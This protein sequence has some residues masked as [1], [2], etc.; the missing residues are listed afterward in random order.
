MKTRKVL[1]LLSKEVQT[2]IFQNT[3][4][5]FGGDDPTPAIRFYDFKLKRKFDEYGLCGFFIFDRTPEGSKY[6]NELSE[7]LVKV[8]F[9]K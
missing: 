1:N 9:T 4:K 7:A 8:T 6:W 3:I 5:D 2:K